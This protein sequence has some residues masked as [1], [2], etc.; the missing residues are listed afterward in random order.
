MNDTKQFLIF[1][2]F[3]LLIS[4]TNYAQGKFPTIDESKGYIYTEFH[5]RLAYPMNSM[6][7]VWVKGN[8]T[9]PIVKLIDPISDKVYKTDIL[10]PPFYTAV[11]DVEMSEIKVVFCNKTGDC[12]GNI[13]L[14]PNSDFEKDSNN[15]SILLYGCFE[16]FEVTQ[17]RR[18]KPEVSIYTGLKNSSFRLRKLFS[19]VAQ[20]ESLKYDKYE[21]RDKYYLDSTNTLIKPL[22]TSAPKLI[23]GTGDQVYVDVAYAAKIKGKHKNPLSAWEFYAK[24]KPLLDV[25][26]YTIFLNKLYNASYSFNELEKAHRRLPALFAIDDHEIR[27]GWGSQGD[28]Y[29][30]GKLNPEF[31]PF[32]NLGKEAFINHQLLISKFPPQNASV[33]LN[34]NKT[35]NYA[36]SVHGK[37]GYMLDLRSARDRLIPQVLGDEQLTHFKTWLNA[38]EDGE[39]IILVSS[40]PLFLR[41]NHR[42]ESAFAAIDSEV[43]DDIAD[44]WSSGFN[45]AERDEL[46]KILT[47]HRLE[48]D[49]KPIFVSGDIHKS[50]LIEIWLDTKKNDKNGNPEKPI[51]FGYE[52]IASGL[53]HEFITSNTKKKLFEI[54]EQQ[55]IGDAH[56]YF[57]YD[58]TSTKATLYPMVR[59]STAEQNFGAI[60]FIN[61]E[62]RLHTFIFRRYNK[63]N[64]LNQYFID[65]NWDKTE[66][67]SN[68]FKF[69]YRRNGEHKD[70]NPKKG[71]F[72]APLANGMNVIIEN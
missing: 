13:V 48:R 42:L 20:H 8:V 36:F 69:H 22:L 41:P 46:F 56:L 28:E 39:T 71:S 35:M 29:S 44:S 10:K 21:R 3:T 47:K 2:I 61:G 6:N 26:D 25:K 7:R 24:P 19:Q 62:V 15:F 55:R 38:L 33:T 5:A 4:W 64:T 53:S 70:Y 51:V 1:F 40:I 23:I 32:Y 43:R 18:N 49:I 14:Y 67:Q 12:E 60:E 66:E 57:Q 17:K 52:I 58:Q 54:T 27:D 16:P 34:E 50:A 59:K 63:Y 31:A 11:L 37:N 45:K 9:H 72:N 30:K 68:E 65:L